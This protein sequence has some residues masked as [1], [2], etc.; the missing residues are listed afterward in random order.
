MGTIK[1]F[2]IWWFLFIFFSWSGNT[3]VKFYAWK[4]KWSFQR[5]FYIW[6]FFG[7]NLKKKLLPFLICELSC[8]NKKYLHL[9]RK[10]LYLSIFELEFEKAIVIFE[11]DALEFLKFEKFGAKRKILKF[12]TK[13]ALI[14]CFGQQFW[15][16][17]VIFEYET[18]NTWFVYF[19]T[20]I[21][22]YYSH[23]WN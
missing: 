17:I 20:A 2:N 7:W 14:R 6:K 3:N 13:N 12:G 21:W 1:I 8:K 16:A 22:K 4:Q 10:M 11:I 19:G 5:K 9:G 18:K 23:I 15:K